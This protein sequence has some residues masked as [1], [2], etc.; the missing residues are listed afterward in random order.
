M[1]M[2]TFSSWCFGIAT[3]V[4]VKSNSIHCPVTNN[5]L[6][7]THTYPNIKVCTFNT[8]F[9]HDQ[10]IIIFKNKLPNENSIN[11]NLSCCVCSPIIHHFS[12]WNIR[13]LSKRSQSPSIRKCYGLSTKWKYICLKCDRFGA[14]R[15][16]AFWPSNTR[17]NNLN[18]RITKTHHD[19]HR[20]N[21]WMNEWRR[22][23]TKRQRAGA[24]F[25]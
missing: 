16:Q 3:D 1:P 25:H 9:N 14:I 10:S 2:L 17:K 18:T 12:T 20:T 24:Q 22:R 23:V 21:E 6:I 15:Y 8:P 5:S 4:Y 7:H 11:Q 13:T 19:L